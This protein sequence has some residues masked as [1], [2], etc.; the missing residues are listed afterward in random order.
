ME[1]NLLPIL[2]FDGKKI[3]INEEISV[4]LRPG[5]TFDICSPVSFDGSARNVGGTI[6]LCGDASVHLRLVCDR[7]G[8]EYDLTL[9]F[10]V[11]ESFKKADEFSGTDDNPDINELTGTAIDLDEILYTNLF[12]NLP[13]KQLCREDCKGLCPICG[14]NLN[15][16]VCGCKSETTDPR[17][18]ILDNLLG[19]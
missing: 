6:E 4:S 18:D 14:A 15:K 7:C 13:S 10:Y 2:N 17:F 8:E 9:C 16:T 12:L 3:R 5:D 1:L 19:K 11:N